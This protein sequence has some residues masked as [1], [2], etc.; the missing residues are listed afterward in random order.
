MVVR[1]WLGVLV[2][3]LCSGCAVQ[4]GR[5]EPQPAPTLLA[6]LP[7]SG[8]R[9]GL[10]FLPPVE[11]HAAPLAEPSL[12]TAAP[13]AQATRPESRRDPARGASLQPWQLQQTP[14]SFGASLAEA[15][16]VFRKAHTIDFDAI[17]NPV[18]RET[19]RFVQDLVR[20]DWRRSGRAGREPFFAWQPPD[21]GEPLLW[22]EELA[23]RNREEWL[24]S[25]GPA[26]LRK[27]LQQLLRRLP[28]VR[29]LELEIA[30]FRAEHVPLTQDYQDQHRGSGRSARWSVRLRPS[31][32][33]DPLEMVFQFGPLRLGSSQRLGKFAFVQPL[34]ERLQAEVHW[35]TDYERGSHWWRAELTYRWS[36]CTTL[37]C[38]YG[39]GLRMLPNTADAALLA[40]DP[41]G[42]PLLVVYAVH[43]F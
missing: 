39:D 21:T 26:H 30:K 31:Q 43:T 41:D 40:A 1:F 16:Q 22:S 27:P 34:G 35:R 23:A 20:E 17:Q 42:P 33:Q 15:E 8:P 9:I 2:A 38:G 10:E 3:C 14:S 24:Q 36:F 5:A 28:L 7:A 37:H 11:D 25:H 19:L 4:P 6:V 29:D 32:L 12:R 13:L 18:E